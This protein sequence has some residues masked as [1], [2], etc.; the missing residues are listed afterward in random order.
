MTPQTYYIIAACLSSFGALYFLQA[1]DKSLKAYT[2][3]KRTF[4]VVY[5]TIAVGFALLTYIILKYLP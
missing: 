5:G 4:A 3:Y 1:V 2:I